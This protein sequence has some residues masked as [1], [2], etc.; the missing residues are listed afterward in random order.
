MSDETEVYEWD[1]D[2]FYEDEMPLDMFDCCGMCAEEDCTDCGE[3]DFDLEE[4]EA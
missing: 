1:E 2:D 3:F 4:N